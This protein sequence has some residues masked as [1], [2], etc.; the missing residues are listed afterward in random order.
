MDGTLDFAND[1]WGRV[2]NS[3]NAT[4]PLSIFV[5][6]QENTVLGMP[7][8]RAWSIFTLSVYRFFVHFHGN[9]I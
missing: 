4:Q 2:L 1:H 9:F 5:K 3:Y 6:L 7:K 8:V